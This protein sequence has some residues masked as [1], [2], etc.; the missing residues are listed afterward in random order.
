VVEPGSRGFLTPTRYD[1]P[2]VTTTSAVEAYSQVL[3]NAGNSAAVSCDGTW[4][5][6]RD[7]IDARVVNDVI[8]GTGGIIDDPSDVGGWLTLAAGTPC[9]DGDHDGMPNAWETQY[10]LDPNSAAD[11]VADAD[12]DGYT[13]VEEFINA[14]DPDNGT[15]V[16]IF[17]DVPET[18]WAREWIEKLYNSGITGGCAINPLRYCPAA[19][20]TRAEISVFLERSMHGAGYTP[21]T[22]VS[23]TFGDTTEHWARY[24]IQALVADGVSSGCGNGSFCPDQALTRDQ[25]AVFLLK[26]EYGAGYFPP[27]ASGTL[28]DDIPASYWAADWIEQLA[29]EGITGGCGPST[30]CP[31]DPVTRAQMAVFL[32]RAFN[33]P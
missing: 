33:F 11:A 10:G 21:P 32:V 23:I 26:A 18:H 19:T 25:M 16:T 1:A 7:G 9:T 28:F 2:Q 30:Y 27:P 31:H 13:N 29:N 5:N 14:T 24:W 12:G 17:A 4:V 20:I 22:D 3:A 15:A 8:Q 6:R